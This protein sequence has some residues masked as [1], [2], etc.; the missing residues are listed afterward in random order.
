MISLRVA[1]GLARA[2]TRRARGT[3]VFCVLAI[4]LGVLA[5]TAIRTLTR[6]LRDD[7]EAQGQTLLGADL[8]LDSSQPLEHD[9]AR[10]LVDDLAAQGARSAASVRFYSMLAR[11]SD[12]PGSA[13]TQLVRVRAVGD[14]FPFYGSIQSIPPDRWAQLGRAPSVLI[15]P[16]VARRLGL[17]PGD[18]VRLGQLEA[19]V[20]GEF[21]RSA[22][23]PAAEF[24]MAPYLFLH[25][26][27]LPATGLLATGSRIQYE[28]LFALPA[29]RAESW[30]EQH[31]EEA[32]ELN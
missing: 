16:S 26:R 14:G 17:S 32:L 7:I 12:K 9:P 21:V 6:S 31:W 27:F 4:A 8:L 1:I 10:A 29:A 3:L 30:K 13:A 25:E 5:I 19:E 23:S 11:A 28:R 15:D 24:S 22:G 20:L 18:R 2:E